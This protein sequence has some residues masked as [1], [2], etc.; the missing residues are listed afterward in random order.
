[1]GAV[2]PVVRLMGRMKEKFLLAVFAWALVFP[3]CRASALS[4]ELPTPSIYFPKGYD[5]NRAER[6]LAV[7]RSGKFKYL[8]G[9]TSYWPP[10][11]STT[12]VYE[13]DATALN[14]FVAALNKVSGVTVRITFSSDLSKETGSALQTGS[15]WVIYSHTAPD[16]ITVRINLAKGALGRDQ[17]E[18]ILPKAKQ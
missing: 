1:M 16:T 6:I 11:W 13:G 14:A 7:L 12:L 5:T 8:G 4:L 3:A 17:P 10:A 15:W 2:R 9:L 18:L